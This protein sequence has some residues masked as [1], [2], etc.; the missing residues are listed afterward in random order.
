MHMS[1]TV[2]RRRKHVQIAGS[3]DPFSDFSHNSLVPVKCTRQENTPQR[4]CSGSL[5]RRSGGR[6]R[7]RG[8]CRWR[9]T[10][11]A[12]PRRR[13]GRA[14]ASSG[15]APDRPERCWPST[16]RRCPQPTR[17][18]SAHPCRWRQGSGARGRSLAASRAV[19][20]ERPARRSAEASMRTFGRR[21]R[22]R[23]RSASATSNWSSHRPS[24]LPGALN[25][26]DNRSGKTKPDAL[27]SITCVLFRR[28]PVELQP[29][30][31]RRQSDG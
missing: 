16:R 20:R 10:S 15:R 21:G 8:S 28:T 2:A 3:L 19:R 27:M 17:R 12:S 14:H 5:R 13:S 31:A 24:R 22:R 7:G 11:A 6:V 25:L 9:G 1:L 30:Y 23:E 29:D 18:P 4:H 26:T